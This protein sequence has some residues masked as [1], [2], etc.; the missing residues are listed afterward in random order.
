MQNFMENFDDGSGYYDKTIIEETTLF[1]EENF[2]KFSPNFK[3]IV[4]KYIK[5][6]SKTQKIMSKLKTTVL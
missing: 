6:E 4:N 2:E 3:I 1:N 5:I